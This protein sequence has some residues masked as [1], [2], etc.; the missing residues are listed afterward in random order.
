MRSVTLVMR[1]ERIERSCYDVDHQE[2]WSGTFN[3]RWCLAVR[4]HTAVQA[5]D[6]T[7]SSYDFEHRTV[8][9]QSAAKVSST[10]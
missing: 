2:C 7:L 5:Q 6:N 10:I 8:E 1:G 3:P 9:Q 4:H